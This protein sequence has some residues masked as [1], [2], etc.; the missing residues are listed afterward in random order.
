MQTTKVANF[1]YVM[2]ELGCTRLMGNDERE[3]AWVK[4]WH[5]CVHVTLISERSLFCSENL[6]KNL[7]S[8]Q[9]L[10]AGSLVHKKRRFN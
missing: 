3:H 4:T 5:R 9:G 2:A 6:Q 7:H 8:S 1:D 10:I